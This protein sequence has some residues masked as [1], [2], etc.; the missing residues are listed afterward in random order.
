MTQSLIENCCSIL[1][2]F[3]SSQNEKGLVYFVIKENHAFADSFFEQ[4]ESLCGIPHN[5]IQMED[6]KD[7]ERLKEMK[8]PVLI[9]GSQDLSTEMFLKLSKFPNVIPV[10]YIEEKKVTY[11]CDM[12]K[13]MQFLGAEIGEQLVACRDF[14]TSLHEAFEKTKSS[15]WPPFPVTFAAGW[16]LHRTAELEAKLRGKE[17]RKQILGTFRKEGIKKVEL[18][19]PD[20]EKALIF[21]DFSI[22]VKRILEGPWT[23]Q[24]RLKLLEVRYDTYSIFKGSL[25]PGADGTAVEVKAAQQRRRIEEIVGTKNMGYFTGSYQLEQT[26]KQLKRVADKQEEKLERKIR[27]ECRVCEKQAVGKHCPC[28]EDVYCGVECQKADFKRHKQTEIHKKWNAEKKK[29]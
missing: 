11:S 7:L 23:N 27:Q 26:T 28:G 12:R 8:G 15:D 9:K 14:T 18:A 19:I 3:L 2:Y 4:L 24:Q 17:Q 16:V 25:E 20:A 5:K 10:V 21:T 22:S 13:I 6:S 29:D 1:G